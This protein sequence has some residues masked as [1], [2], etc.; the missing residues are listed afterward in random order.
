MSEWQ[1]METAPKDGTRVL[2]WGCLHSDCTGEIPQAQI[3]YH[4][5][6]G[7]CSDAWGGHEPAYWMHLPEPPL[8]IRREH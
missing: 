8:D 1:P 2:T 5:E 4:T 7:W 6:Y 3:S